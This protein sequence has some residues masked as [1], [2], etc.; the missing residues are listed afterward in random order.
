MIHLNSST[1][2][3]YFGWHGELYGTIDCYSVAV[4]RVYLSDQQRLV[5]S[6][7][8]GLTIFPIVVLNFALSFGLYKLGDWKQKS[9]FFVFVLSVSDT[10]SGLVA[11]PAYVILGT[12]LGRERSCWFERVSLFVAQTTLHFSCC[13]ILAIALE[14]YL[15]ITSALRYG[16]ESRGMAGYLTRL[17]STTKGHYTLL[18]VMFILSVYH[19]LATQLFGKV[20]SDV[21]SIVNMFVYLLILAAIYISYV[22]MYFAIR[23]HVRVNRPLNQT[24]NQ[25][26]RTVVTILI[27]YT[28]IF[29][30]FIVTYFWTAYYIYVK[31]SAV[32]ITLRFT[33]Y[34]SLALVCVNGAINAVV[35]LKV[36]RQVMLYYYTHIFHCLDNQDSK[37][38]GAARDAGGE[39]QGRTS[40]RLVFLQPA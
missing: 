39:E 28:V 9:T 32:P 38:E 31:R 29:I 33:H 23:K 11:V 19:G 1:K 14:R 3:H 20:E 16:I 2:M 35:L 26:F 15:H 25:A 7:S 34:L 30:P 13:T 6:I 5:L 24:H 18:P 21:P 36:N 12:V 4:W 27:S 37:E 8:Y 10:V 17:T 22:R 40:N